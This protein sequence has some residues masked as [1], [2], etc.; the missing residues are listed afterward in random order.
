M[1]HN[2]TKSLF[3]TRLLSLGRAMAAV[4]AVALGA[5]MLLSTADIIL[6]YFF[7]APINGASEIVAMLLVIAATFGF[8]YC[9]L[10][11]GHIRITVFTERFPGMQNNFN[12]F[13][14]I[15]CII[16]TGL[17]S[18][19]AVLQFWDYLH[20]TRGHLSDLLFIP[21]WP[22]MLLETI[23]IAFLC[24]V[25]IIRL[26]KALRGEDNYGTD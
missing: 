4:S 9:E 13:A 24:I 20:K 26:V 15:V 12:I 19:R 6:R 11:N 7:L 16:T 23:G 25:F 21:Y 18:W 17:L 14:Y 3:D 1:Q 10:R 2:G 5:M 8:G 22:F